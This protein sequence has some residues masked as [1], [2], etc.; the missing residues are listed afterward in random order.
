MVTFSIERHVLLREFFFLISDLACFFYFQG[1]SSSTLDMYMSGSEK[2]KQASCS[3]FTNPCNFR[4]QNRNFFIS[5][6]F[7]SAIPAARKNY[8][9]LTI[10]ASSNGYKRTD[11]SLSLVPTHMRTGSRGVRQNRVCSTL[12]APVCTAH[13][14][15]SGSAGGLLPEPARKKLPLAQRLPRKPVHEIIFYFLIF[16]NFQK[17]EKFIFNDSSFFNPPFF[18]MPPFLPSFFFPLFSLLFLIK[19]NSSS[20]FSFF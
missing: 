3:S 2:A 9:F 18:E 12:F 14:E 7:S 19:K 15:H 10:V 20:F 6:F 11:F 5:Y 16:S 1:D 8:P 4:V 13:R 17:T